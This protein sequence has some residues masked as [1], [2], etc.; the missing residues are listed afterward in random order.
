M[1][2]NQA[3]VL[4]NEMKWNQPTTSN[5]FICFYLWKSKP[6]SNIITNNEGMNV[7]LGTTEYPVHPLRINK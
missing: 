1:L 6:T 2:A 7:E 5:K 3:P 4:I